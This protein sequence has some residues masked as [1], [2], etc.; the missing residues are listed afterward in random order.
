[1]QDLLEPQEL[2]PRHLC[3]AVVVTVVAHG[4]EGGDDRGGATRIVAIAV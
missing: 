1:M 3:S 4:R 2:D